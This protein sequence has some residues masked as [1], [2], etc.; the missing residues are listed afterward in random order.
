MNELLSEA[1]NLML[2]GMGFVFVFLTVLVFVTGY[3]SKLVNRFAPPVPEPSA[4]PAKAAPA[5]SAMDDA[6]LMAV[7]SAAIKKY[8][9]RHK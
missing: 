5:P 2:A 9:S 8:R 3:M 4:A 6:E 7:I 1:F